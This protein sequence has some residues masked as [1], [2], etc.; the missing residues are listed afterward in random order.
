MFQ[1][2][3]KHLPLISIVIIGFFLRFLFLL[4]Y[5]D[6]WDDEMFSFIYSQKAWPKGIIYWLW[7]TNP[8]LHML[9]LKIWFFIFP[10]TE[11]WARIPSLLF[12]TATIVAI[13][14][15]AKLIWNK[16]I[17]LLSAFFI[18]IHS[19]LMFWSATARTYSL[20][21]LLSTLSVLFFYKIFIIQKYQ[22]KDKIF[23][24]LCNLFLLFSHLT[25]TLL[26]FS[27]IVIIISLNYKKIYSYF[28]IN[29]LP[30]L[31]SGTWLFISFFIKRN[32]HLEK[33]WLLNI[34]QDFFTFFAP[35]INILVGIPEFAFGFVIIIFFMILLAYF[36]YKEIKQKNLKLF[37]LLILA[38]L[39]IIP[40]S[41]FNLWHVKMLIFLTPFW[42][43]LFAWVIFQ[44]IKIFTKKYTLLFSLLLLIFI[45]SPGIYFANRA[46]PINNWQT[47]QKFLDQNC[48]TSE[49]CALLCNNFMLKQQADR[50]IKT[51][52]DSYFFDLEKE[53]G[54]DWNDLVTKKN[55]LYFD[56][57]EKDLDDWWQKKELNNYDKIILLQ[58]ENDF[59]HQLGPTA[60]KN[61]FEKNTKKKS[62]PLLGDYYFNIYVKNNSTTTTIQ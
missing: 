15:L 36:S 35:L 62:A 43:I 14:K 34:K 18:A 24:A 54:M 26:I 17:A 12:G 22:N 55:Y 42:S 38:I 52:N 60:E 25:A 48:P 33:S 2:I 19:Y 49:N 5:G 56:F 21:V 32:N 57:S 9:I 31:F 50:Y 61:N 59:V 1:K 45:L 6:F 11:F 16:N 29:F 53:D 47:V 30:F 40:L 27:Q 20:L 39:P 4:K 8:P 37:S 13:Y 44:I 7:E 10:T 28:K 23:F 58:D 46:T 51:S 41:F 3:K